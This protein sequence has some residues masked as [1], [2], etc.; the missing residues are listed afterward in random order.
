MQPHRPRSHDFD[1]SPAEARTAAGRCDH[2][3]AVQ[4]EPRRFIGNP[5][6]RARC[7]Y[8]ALALDVMNE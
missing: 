1:Q 6:D 4:A 8:D 3:G 7:E 2:Q 5:R